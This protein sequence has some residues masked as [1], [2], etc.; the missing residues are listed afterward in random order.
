METPL[1]QMNFTKT[2]SSH[3]LVLEFVG[4]PGAGKTTVFHEVVALLR[5]QGVTVAARDEI[6]QQWQR[7]PLWQ[8]LWKLI[9]QT[10]NQWRILLHSLILASQVKPSN[11]SSFA[12]AIKIFANVKRIDAIARHQDSQL[13]LLDQGLLQ[14]TWSVGITGTLPSLNILK[15]ELALL[16]HQRPIAI[17]YFQI[18]VETAIERVQNRPTAESRL[19]QMDAKAAHQLLSKYMDYLQDIINC[20]QT[21]N[22]PILEIDSLLPID[23]KAKNILFWIVSDK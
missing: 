9:P 11:W 4:L 13:I 6:L 23:Q 1:D 18:D 8:R 16:L 5:E 12:K 3:P 22:I 21:F 19:D 17:V 7:Q 20:V 10:Q 14:E 15:Q 2:T